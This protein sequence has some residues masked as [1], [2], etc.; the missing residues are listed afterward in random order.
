[1]NASDYQEQAAHLVV[2]K[3][4]INDNGGSAVAME[5]IHCPE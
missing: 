5:S 1:M 3:Y 2:I 4:V